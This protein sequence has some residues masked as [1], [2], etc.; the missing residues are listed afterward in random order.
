MIYDTKK[1][2]DWHTKSG[3]QVE[4]NV[5]RIIKDPNIV[6]LETIINH[7]PVTVEAVLLPNDSKHT[8]WWCFW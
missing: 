5:A 1:S 8:F 6:L 3:V 7:S 4:S 2:K